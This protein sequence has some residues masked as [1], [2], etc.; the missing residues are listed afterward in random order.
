MSQIRKGLIALL[1]ALVLVFPAYG[2]E[3][4]SSTYSE[5]DAS[6]NTASP[7]GWPEGMAMSG[8][9]N[10]GRQMMGAV[11]RFWGRVN[12]AYASTGSANAYVLTPT[13]SL[14]AYV[15]GERYSFRSNFANTGSA[16]LNISS[17]GA[18]TIKR[19]APSGKVNLAAGEIQ[20]GQPVTVEYDGTDMIMVT[21]T[22][23]SGMILLG[24]FTASGGSAIDLTS[25]V[26]STYRHYRIV[27][28]SILP[29]TDT[30]DLWLRV[31]TDNGS[32]F[33]SSSSYLYSSV[34][35]DSSAST[36]TGGTS[37]G[38]DVKIVIGSSLS[39]A[40]NEIYAGHIDI[41]TVANQFRAKFSGAYLNAAGNSVS[42]D[43]SGHTGTLTVD[44]IRIMASTGNIS[45]TVRIYGIAE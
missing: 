41:W 1:L 19:M 36:V 34:R 18:K 20:N 24:T 7:D 28:H 10:S 3:I 21:P 31:S 26:T 35:V 43:G 42:I 8:I 11:K 29:A 14:G 25:V 27:L 39:N 37:S 33:V 15:T 44:A 23:G 4:S 2:A 45:G 40:S 32:T 30:A 38:A 12:G 13:V 9:N 6:N 22:A 17:L 5:T 16:T